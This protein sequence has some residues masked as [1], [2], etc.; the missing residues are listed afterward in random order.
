MAALMPSAPMTRDAAARRG[1]RRLAD[2]TGSF[3]VEA[4]V[5]AVIVL[6]VGAGALQMTD[7][8]SQLS[9]QQKALAMAG[10]LAQSEQE[11]L[12]ANPLTSLS[13]LRRTTTRATGGRTFTIVSRTDWVNEAGGTPNCATAG[14]TAD[15]MRLRT[16]VSSPAMRKPIV[17]DSLVAP[18]ARSF[19]PDQGSLAVQVND[20]AAGPIA[21]LTVTL[22][23]PATLSDATNANGCVLWGYLPAGSGYTVS[24]ASAGYVKPDGSATINEPAS[25]V[26]DQTSNVNLLYDRAGGV[27]ATFQTKRPG[28]ATNM[29]TTPQH[30][31]VESPNAS[32]VPR[33]FALGGGVLATGLVLFPWTAPY[34]I[35][36][37]NCSTFR[38]T[39]NL[40]SASAPQGATSATVSVLI[41]ALN[42]KVTKNSVAV[43]NGVA[44]VK[45]PCGVLY[46]RS[47]LTD[48]TIADPGFP[49]GNLTV[50]C[51][52]DATGS[53]H[54]RPNATVANTNYAG[55]NVTYDI[56]TG[57][58][59][60]TTGPCP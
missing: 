38:P 42:V 24:A 58:A 39:S 40:G 13:N 27:R 2:E 12:R 10:N 52:A 5:S 46:T 59:S 11:T 18:P 14:S 48:G 23:G 49:P 33:S 15:Y 8:G 26:G 29:S 43:P 50:V 45:S 7:R 47:T 53:R 19:Q 16:T 3:L 60:S 17:V 36:A 56:G 20:R 55:T 1:L 6:I 9:A 44:Q 22:A 51:L 4:M 35:Y 54:L 28:A 32:F 25:V 41:P 34:T 31:M 30:A 37:D 21:G 57:N